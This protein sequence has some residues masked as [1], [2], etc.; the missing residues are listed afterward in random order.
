MSK[1]SVPSS[2]QNS[3]FVIPCP[4]DKFGEFISHLLGKPQ[5]IS[6]GFYGSFSINRDDISNFYDLVQHRLHEQQHASLIQFTV[7]TSY[8]DGSSVEV[9]S[10]KDFTEYAEIRPLIPRAISMSWVYLVKFPNS[11]IPERQQIDVS[12]RSNNQKYERNSFGKESFPDSDED[13]VR[14]IYPRSPPSITGSATFRISHTARSW[15]MDIEGLL[16]SHIKNIMHFSGGNFRSWIQAYSGTLGFLAS[17]LLGVF[18]L[19]AGYKILTYLWQKRMAGY[20]SIFQNSHDTLGSIQLKLDFIADRLTGRDALFWVVLGIIYII[21]AFFI[22]II[23][24]ISCSENADSSEPSFII[25][26][27]KSIDYKDRMLKRYNN[28]FKNFCLTFILSALSGVL[29]NIIF[30]FIWA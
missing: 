5:V 16:T 30:V 6:K 29:G 17:I 28:N 11:S 22:C 27:K 9:T 20:Q 10:I 2:P 1:A 15:G 3:Y 24:G 4:Q 26:S 14:F 7:K 8:D 13:A 21:M 18:F 25:L 23:T 12:L 19:S